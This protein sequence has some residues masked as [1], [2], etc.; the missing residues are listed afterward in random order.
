MPGNELTYE[1]CQKNLDIKRQS[2]DGLAYMRSTNLIV[3]FIRR[4]E[5]E[6]IKQG[7]LG[8]ARPALPQKR[9]YTN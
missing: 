4:Q 9:T 6:D 5:G 8:Y 3:H 7:R 1:S 2:C